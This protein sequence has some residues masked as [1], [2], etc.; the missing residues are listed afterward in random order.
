M[1]EAARQD[2]ELDH[3]RLG[4]VEAAR[5]AHATPPRRARMR[6]RGPLRRPPRRRRPRAPNA[7]APR[8]GAAPGPS[9]ATVGQSRRPVRQP[10][11]MRTSSTWLA[12]AC[13][14]ARRLSSV[15]RGAERRDDPVARRRRSGR[16]ARCAPRRRASTVVTIVSRIIGMA[17][18]PCLARSVW[19]ASA[20]RVRSSSGRSAATPQS[21]GSSCA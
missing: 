8:R 2:R 1:V 7:R 4:A 17:Q 16:A 18:P 19:P 9:V 13:G 14:T 3:R 6:K 15:A 5:T 10:A 20:S 12:T 11:K 21:S